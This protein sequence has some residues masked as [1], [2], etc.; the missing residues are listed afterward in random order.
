MIFVMW[1]QILRQN[2]TKLDALCEY[3]KLSAEQSALL[4]RQRGFVLNLPLRLASKIQKGTLDDPLFRQ[5]VPLKQEEESPLAFVKDPVS[6]CSF[7]ATP[8]LLKKYAGRALLVTTGACAM[9]CRYCFR[10]NYD[11]PSGDKEF[12]D[13]VLQIESD[14]T[15][16]E[17]I[18]SGG[19]PLSLSDHI[20][21][22]LLS[23]LDA[24]PHITKI[25]FH[26]RF[27]IGIPERIDDAFL[28]VLEN[29][30]CQIWF[31]IHCNHPDELD[32]DVLSALTRLRKLGI[33]VCNQAVLL[34]EVNDTLPILKKLCEKLVDNGIAPYYIHQLDRIEGG[35]HFEVDEQKGKLLIEQLTAELPGY[36]VPR[37]VREVP[38]YTS[39]MPL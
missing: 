15:I 26:T 18:L 32:D 24:I 10:Q 8:R 13:E 20:L 4:S 22:S 33:P 36:A 39:K 12:A 27:P 29:V 35:A 17:V 14:P 37:Y 2:I 30:R 3:L 31:V 34:H 23:R 21:A 16:H 19:D 6:D 11:Y 25:R 38:H 28:Q 7:Q 5:F 1:K 9:H